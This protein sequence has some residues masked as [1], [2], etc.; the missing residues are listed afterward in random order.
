MK[1]IVMGLGILQD[2][3]ILPRLNALKMDPPKRVRFA[4]ERSGL[5]VRYLQAEI[6]SLDALYDALGLSGYIPP[7]R[8]GCTSS[9]R[10]RSKA[11]ATT[12]ASSSRPTPTA[13]STSRP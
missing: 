7:T 6:I 10:A 11:C 3:T 2:R 13:R 5:T 8:C 1:A 4:F 9:C 12:S